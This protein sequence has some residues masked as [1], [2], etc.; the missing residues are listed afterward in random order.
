MSAA[1]DGK[2]FDAQPAWRRDF[3]IDIGRDNEVARRDF[4][5]FLVLTSLAFAAGQVCIGLLSWRR[6][7]QPPA[8][9]AAVARLDEVQTTEP[10]PLLPVGGSL[11]FHYPDESEPCILLRPDAQT[12]L[13][14]NQKCTHLS[15]AVLPRLDEGR[16]HCPCHHGTFDLASGRPLA[17]PPRRPLTRIQL[18]VQ[19]GV[20]Y[21]VGVELRTT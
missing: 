13:A 2:P 5:N 20:V 3:P 11:L 21:A 12:V 1:P 6:G 16:L 9:P 17:G 7:R 15:C 19:G 14:Y 18:E 8:A 10:L 4:T